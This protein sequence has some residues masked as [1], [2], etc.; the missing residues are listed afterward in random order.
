[1]LK[2]TNRSTD[3]KRIRLTALD[4]AMSN[5]DNSVGAIAKDGKDVLICLA[6]LP[7][8]DY[9]IVYARNWYFN[10]LTEENVKV[11]LDGEEVYLGEGAWEGLR[12]HGILID[13]ATDFTIGGDDPD[14]DPYSI[15]RFDRIVNTRKERR[16]L[17]IVGQP[18]FL[19]VPAPVFG[20]APEGMT[21][22][23]DDR[24]TIYF[25]EYQV[26][27][28]A[29][30]HLSEQV[31]RLGQDW[32]PV[33]GANDPHLIFAIELKDAY[34]DD[35]LE[36]G[37]TIQIDGG[38]PM[39][40][41]RGMEIPLAN[42]DY[43]I[44][45]ATVT[46]DYLPR[47]TYEGKSLGTTGYCGESELIHGI[48]IAPWIPLDDFQVAVNGNTQTATRVTETYDLG[49]VVFRNTVTFDHVALDEGS[50]NVTLP[51]EFFGV[52]YCSG[53]EIDSSGNVRVYIGETSTQQRVIV[54][55]NGLSGIDGQVALLVIYVN[56]D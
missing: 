34:N 37:G 18:G 28:S 21:V 56:F 43:I 26:E 40:Y 53:G 41:Q 4:S 32:V 39:T 30:A 49:E 36:A 31:T 10:N 23:E 13:Q 11:F 47:V 14:A 48:N 7:A 3:S 2:I 55:P 16:V 19:P 42:K 20:P 6:P 12:S 54:Y 1:M 46:R 29:V 44:E 22:I 50:I 24:V 52:S 33:I 17:E 5:I 51:P 15:Q 27:W 8:T 45:S 35:Y 25:G 38:A 9:Q